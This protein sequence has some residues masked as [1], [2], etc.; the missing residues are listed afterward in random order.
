MLTFLAE[1]FDLL[2]AS[3]SK[4]RPRDSDETLHLTTY[5][6]DNTTKIQDTHDTTSTL[7]PRYIHGVSSTSNTIHFLY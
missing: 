1:D 2:P 6:H 7:F 3:L 5:L 4:R